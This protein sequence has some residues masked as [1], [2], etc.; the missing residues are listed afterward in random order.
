MSVIRECA[1]ARSPARRGQN[2][3]TLAQVPA[4]SAAWGETRA[5]MSS[6][7]VLIRE[8][9]IVHPVYHRPRVRIG[10]VGFSRAGTEKGLLIGRQSL[11]EPASLFG[12][13]FQKRV[14]Q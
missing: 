12:I 4:A 1:A 14:V 2:P 7:A 13:Q 5:E 10:L 9:S 11:H 8:S 6:A 3:V